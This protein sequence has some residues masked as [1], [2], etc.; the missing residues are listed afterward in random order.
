MA[1]YVGAARWTGGTRGGAF[2]WTQD[3]GGWERL[4]D[5]LP[6]SLQVQAI[7]VHP[8]QP[9]IVYLGAA[10]G[11]YRSGDSGAHWERLDVP[12]GVQ[13]WSVL[14]HPASPRVLY[15]GTSPVG[16]LR[17]D[18]GGDSWRTLPDP[19]QPERLKM[20]FACRVMR[21]AVDPAHRD[22]VYAALEVGGVMRSLDGGETWTD[23]A[24]ELVAL[25]QQRPELRS[26]IQ[27]DSETEGMLDA[28]AV[29]VS[30]ARPETVYLAVRMGLFQSADCGSSWRNLE[31]G[32]FSPLTYARDIRVSPHDPR[33]LYACLSPAARS[34]DGSLYRSEDLGASWTRF[35]RGIRARA[36]MMAV[37]LDP[38]D[39]AAVHCVSR[40]G[41]VF[42]TRDAGQTW[43]ESRLPAGVED[44]Y[45]IACG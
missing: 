4:G 33:V 24:A 41:Q 43:E 3:Q 18:D 30:A 5:G 44:V 2:R 11:L 36:T 42:A 8:R 6:E 26:R 21:L 38:R 14:V 19:R 27:S 22:H 20:S 35:D 13:I 23:C 15:A 34:E 1:I 31:V 45:A 25:A 28:H 40:C 32:R 39:P 37:A 29:C 17:S 7:T 12:R 10:D 16:V 9:E